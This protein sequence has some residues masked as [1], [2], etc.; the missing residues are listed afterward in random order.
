MNKDIKDIILMFAPLH[1]TQINPIS[2]NKS[3]KILQRGVILPLLAQMLTSLVYAQTNLFKPMETLLNESQNVK[4]QKILNA[5]HLKNHLLVRIENLA[6]TQTQGMLNIVLPNVACDNLAFT[7]RKVEYTSENDYYWYGDIRG[8]DEGACLTGTIML[9]ARNGQK[10]G[11]ISL[12]EGTFEYQ[13]LGNNLQVLS[14]HNNNELPISKICGVDEKTPV[15]IDPL[16]ARG[17]CS[18]NTIADERLTVLVL[19]TP[20]AISIEPD[21]YNRA[22]LAVRQTNQILANSK[23]LPTNAKLILAGALPFNF[24]ETSSNRAIITDIISLTTNINAQSIR[25]LYNADLV[26]LMTNGNYANNSKYIGYAAAIGPSS[27]DAYAIVETAYST[28]RHL[29]FAHEVGHLF[30][31]RHQ[32]TFQTYYQRAHFF[33][34]GFLNLKRNITVMHTDYEP[35]RRV[36]HFSNPDADYKNRATGD[37]SHNNALKINQT[38]QTVANFRQVISVIPPTSFNIAITA[39]ATAMECTFGIFANVN[40]TCGSAPF[41][42]VWENSLDGITWNAGTTTLTNSPTGTYR[43]SAP[44][45][46]AS[47]APY[48]VRSTVTD[49]NGNVRVEMT[50]VDI[51]MQNMGGLRT[52]SQEQLISSIAPNPF[53]ES[54]VVKLNLQKTETIQIE[55][56]NMYGTIRRTL[57]TQILSAGEHQI[58]I[59]RADLPEGLYSL[60]LTTSNGY[61][62]TKNIIINL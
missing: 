51:L 35:V 17:S 62:E 44:C 22:D 47:N 57:T 48:F 30:G 21:I 7:A 60:R 36:H 31:A 6:T 27:P 20:A 37:G 4:Y 38:G 25:D 42:I 49:A 16:V 56:S 13:E 15:G 55:L 41:N 2:M 32:D 45:L 10:Y 40:I 33:Y 12:D 43:F 59:A 52:A 5:P 54:T 50:L 61:V 18:S 23:I 19:F 26:I 46:I 24:T 8:E 9:I 29:T 39:P 3:C 1:L 53:A 11:Q 34:T 28:S 58:T 14:E